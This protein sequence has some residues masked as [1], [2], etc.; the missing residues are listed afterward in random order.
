MT[1]IASRV[2]KSSASNPSGVPQRIR[3]LDLTE[4]PDDT[5]RFEPLSFSDFRNSPSNDDPPRPVVADFNS[6]ISA[7]RSAAESL[8]SLREDCLNQC[9]HEVINLG[10]AIAE[11]LLRRTLTTEPGEVVAL[12][13]SALSWVIEPERVRLH[14]HPDDCDLVEQHSDSLHPRGADFLEFIRDDQLTRGDCLVES[15]AGQ[16]DARL[17]TMLDRIAEELR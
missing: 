9:Q 6:A 13:R 12:A 10:I 14:L 17:A 5:A 7:L 8:Q 11:R 15:A 1:A 4:Q 16:L 2:L 3:L